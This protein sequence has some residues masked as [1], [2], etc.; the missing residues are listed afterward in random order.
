MYS[1]RKLP[2]L[3]TKPGVYLLKD[4][5]GDI[6]YVGKAANL[7]NRVRSYFASPVKLPSKLSRMM[8]RVSDVEVIIADSEQ[9]ALL[10]ECN[11]I[12]RYRPHYNVRLKDDKSFPYLKIDLK[13]DWPRICITRRLEK[14]NGRY[15]GPYANAGSVRRTLALLQKVFP[16][17]SCVKVPA[18]S[19]RACLDYHI[20]RCLGPCVGA[21]TREEYS[22]MIRQVVLFLEG[23]QERVVRDLRHKMEQAAANL[24]FERAAL[25]RNQMKA[26][27][28]VIEGQKL[29][30][31]VKGD[32]DVIAFVQSKDLAYVEIFFIRN[33]K[34]TGREHFLLEGVRDVEPEEIMA[35]F[36]K[37]FY[38]SAT[39]IPPSVLLPETPAEKEALEDWL[40]N[41]RGG[42][43]RLW[44]PRRGEKN[45]L[46]K[47]VIDNARQGMEQFRQR[48]LTSDE[49]LGMALAEL[50]ERLQ[51]KQTPERMECYDISNIQGT[52]AVGSMVVFEKGLPKPSHYRRFKVKG[53]W[54]ADDYAMLQE[55]LRRRF[56]RAKDSYETEEGENH[57]ARR[58]DLVIVD[59]G[60]G[61]LHAAQQAMQD[62]GLDIPLIS[63]AKE[64]E[65]IFILQQAEPVV[66]PFTSPALYLAQRIRDEAHRFAL[67]YHKRVRTR[68]LM[69][70]ALDSIP[71]IGPKRKREL[72]RR[73][74]SRKAIKEAP[75]EDLAATAG[76][77]RALAEKIKESL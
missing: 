29:A 55:I 49:A 42:K 1:L 12:K 33:G 6:L 75:L 39:S 19:P 9:D 64:R 62:L 57:W 10:L 16:F 13:D 44:A 15:F 59:G 53:V 2:E 46:V 38:S 18:D 43:V 58:P 26:I 25:L 52:S 51:L 77:S 32:Q 70:S 24:E 66:L 11:L 3:P 74:G 7:R 8:G 72:W 17:R 50:R 67:H 69:A 63:I 23:R 14:G 45:K 34:L 35:S 27:E 21:V 47:I 31:A 5:T 76:I 22:R 54:Q 4:A 20:H 48:Q 71:G 30:A 28:Q 37:Q 60:K 56:K 68:R 61:Q 73:F 65:E 36:I 40:K 41:R